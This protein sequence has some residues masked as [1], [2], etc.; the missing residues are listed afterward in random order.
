MELGSNAHHISLCGWWQGSSLAPGAN[1]HSHGLQHHHTYSLRYPSWNLSKQ[2]VSGYACNPLGLSQRWFSSSIP[3]QWASSKRGKRPFVSPER[4]NMRHQ[5]EYR[6]IVAPYDAQDAVLRVTGRVF[7]RGRDIQQSVKKMNPVARLVR[8]LHIDDALVQL[9]LINKKKAARALYEVLMAGRAA[10]R[11]KQLKVTELVVDEALVLRAAYARRP[12]LFRAKGGV[13]YPRRSLSHVFVR[14]RE[15][16][17]AA[18]K[19][20]VLRPWWERR[21]RHRCTARPVKRDW[22]T[23]RGEYAAVSGAAAAPAGA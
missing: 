19:T 20:V 6:P 10:A 14:L 9:A 15:V 3:T 5:P 16:P 17:G 21:A 4:R 12:P 1:E 2:A 8:R 7:A 22:I 11:Q 18:M 13:H 23:T